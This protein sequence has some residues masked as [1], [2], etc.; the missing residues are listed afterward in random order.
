[1]IWNNVVIRQ[2]FFYRFD[3]TCL[4]NLLLGTFSVWWS[5]SISW[6]EYECLQ[7]VINILDFL[8]SDLQINLGGA[9]IR[10]VEHLSRQNLTLLRVVIIFKY[11]PART[12]SP[13]MTFNTW[14]ILDNL[15]ILDN[16]FQGP[17]DILDRDWLFAESVQKDE[18]FLFLRIQDSVV[19]IH[20]LFKRWIDFDF[21][22]LASLFLS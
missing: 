11:T 12:L 16:L 14:R 9:D 8:I 22:E 15:I 13:G 5:G 10:M 7:I 19:P 2:F 18:P 6:S 3:P 20:R 17:V 1:M 21:S 4:F